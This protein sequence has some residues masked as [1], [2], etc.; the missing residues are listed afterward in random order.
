MNG[1]VIDIKGLVSGYR[2]GVSSTY[3]YPAFNAVALRGELI[4]LIGRNGVGKSTLLRTLAR[5]QPSLDGNVLL[6]G[7]T[8]SRYQVQSLHSW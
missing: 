2:N 1:I 7:L 4:A 6:K 8:F 3:R 5:L